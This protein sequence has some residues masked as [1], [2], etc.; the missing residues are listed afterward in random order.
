MRVF[1]FYFLITVLSS[2]FAF[3]SLGEI[4]VSAHHVLVHSANTYVADYGLRVR[5][6]RWEG[7]LEY[8]P[9][10]SSVIGYVAP[11]WRLRKNGFFQP[12]AYLGLGWC[13]MP[14][15]V[16][17]VGMHFQLGPVALRIDIYYYLAVAHFRGLRAQ[18]YGISWTF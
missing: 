14:A 16:P 13:Y 11:V 2:F 18:N 8:I 4:E 17:G 12:H 10:L 9:D 6:N 3:E 1:S 15:V 5:V 7:T